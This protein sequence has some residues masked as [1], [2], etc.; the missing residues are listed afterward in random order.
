[1]TSDHPALRAVSAR[2]IARRAAAIH[3]SRSNAASTQGDVSPV[4]STEWKVAVGTESTTAVYEPGDGTAALPL[5]VCAHGAGGSM[6][7][8]GMLATA[9]AFREHGVGVVR[10]NFLYKEKGSGRPDPMPLLME[11]TAAV[12][13]HARRELA[14]ERL[15]IGG[16]SMGGRAAS[17]LAADGYSADGLLLLAYPLHPAGQPAKLRDA[18]LPKIRMPVLAFSGTRDALCT[19]ALMERA[20]ET[21][22]APWDMRWIE[23]ADHSFHVLKSSGTTD[24]AVMDRIA[25]ASA[26]WLG[27]LPS[28]AA[29]SS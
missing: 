14:P 10:F 27:G 20:L 15:V 25:A 22:T 11:T 29:K 8:R 24:A 4:T 28:H 23:G 19:R 1:M 13:A 7:D 2:S 5:F 17:M 12:V 26:A 6:A 3:A 21:V 9:R 18:H 16:R